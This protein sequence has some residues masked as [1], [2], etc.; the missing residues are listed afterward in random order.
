[1]ARIYLVNQLV[2]CGI[3]VA[4]SLIDT[5]V[6]LLAYIGHRCLGGTFRARPLEPQA[7]SSEGFLIN[8]EYAK[9]PSLIIVVAWHLEL[10]SSVTFY[11]LPH[12]ETESIAFTEWA[13]RR[14]Q[15]LAATKASRLSK[16]QMRGFWVNSFGWREASCSRETRDWS[17][18]DVR[19]W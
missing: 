1:M 15:R 11:A 6:D 7:N 19:T 3:D 4:H 18:Y 17:G 16:E 9:N 8:G 5:G 13:R 2:R 12:Q 10:E 14:E